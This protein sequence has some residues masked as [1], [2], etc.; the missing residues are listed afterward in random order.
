[1][2]VANYWRSQIIVT[3]AEMD[4]WEA[5]ISRYTTEKKYLF[6]EAAKL[7]YDTCKVRFNR[8]TEKFASLQFPDHTLTNTLCQE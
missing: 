1:M 8:A 4:K 3:K 7:N 2:Q 6:V 5:K